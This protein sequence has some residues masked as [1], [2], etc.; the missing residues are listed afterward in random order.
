VRNICHV[1]RVC[2]CNEFEFY[3]VTACL[4]L[5]YVLDVIFYFV[6]SGNRRRVKLYLTVFNCSMFSLL[7]EEAESDILDIKKT[8]LK[9]DCSTQT[10]CIEYLE[11][12]TSVSRCF[13]H[14]HGQFS[15]FHVYSERVFSVFTDTSIH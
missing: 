4:C 2:P 12:V 7:F 8:D 3:Y 13:V 1:C 15:R 5:C 9:L 10:S 11:N 14:Y 6:Y